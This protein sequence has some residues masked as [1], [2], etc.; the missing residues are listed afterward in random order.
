VVHAALL[1]SLALLLI[2]FK[3]YPHSPQQDPSIAVFLELREC[4]YATR[5][6]IVMSKRRQGYMSSIGR[7]VY[8]SKQSV[9]KF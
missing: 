7:G 5:F 8:I 3:C 4:I 6:L 2:R 9:C 1:T